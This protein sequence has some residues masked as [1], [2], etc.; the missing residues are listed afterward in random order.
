M[1][2]RLLHSLKTGLLSL[3]GLFTDGNDRFF[4]PILHFN[5][6]NSYSSMYLKPF[7]TKS[8]R[9]IA[10]YSSWPAPFQSGS[11]IGYLCLDETVSVPDHTEPITTQHSIMR[12]KRS[13]SC[14]SLEALERIERRCA[15]RIQYSVPRVGVVVFLIFVALILQFLLTTCVWDLFYSPKQIGSIGICCH[16]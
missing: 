2:Y 16:R 6:W 11:L 9:S 1:L 12:P 3:L 5:K 13:A 14:A 15:A 4:F 7:R 8:H 10:H